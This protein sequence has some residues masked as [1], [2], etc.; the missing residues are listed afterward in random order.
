MCEKW[1]PCAAPDLLV[2]DVELAQ[3]FAEGEAPTADVAFRIENPTAKLHASYF[4]F[5]RPGANG[6]ATNEPGP[7]DY[8]NE[9]W[10]LYASI[11]GNPDVRCNPV[12]LS[13]VVPRTEAARP[14]PDSY[15][16]ESGVKLIEG[17]VHLV[18]NPGSSDNDIMV[19]RVIWEPVDCSMTAKERAYWFAKCSAKRVGD[20]DLPSISLT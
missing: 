8:A 14:L 6:V 16:A 18:G 12:F 3:Y 20:P 9:T 19:L 17:V 11:K 10:Q 1:D 7:H 15:E 4:V 13:S 5:A 2:K